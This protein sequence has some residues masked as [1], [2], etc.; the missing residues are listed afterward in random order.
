[1]ASRC[2][3]EMKLSN[4]NDKFICGSTENNNKIAQGFPKWQLRWDVR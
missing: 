1:M 3:D 2:C 4:A